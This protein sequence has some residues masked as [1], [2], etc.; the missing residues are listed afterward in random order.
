[1]TRN[2]RSRMGGPQPI[3]AVRDTWESGQRSVS[4]AWLQAQD[5][6]SSVARSWGE[7]LGLWLGAPS[8]GHLGEGTAALR[9]L[10]EAALAGAQAWM[11][12]P[13]AWTGTGLSEFQQAIVRLMNARA[14]AHQVWLQS[15][16]RPMRPLDGRR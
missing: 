15:L 9:E 13:L 12:L 4:E 5:V 3:E 1:V 16:A 10:Q 11:R 14:R 7:S 6:W 8:G 2:E